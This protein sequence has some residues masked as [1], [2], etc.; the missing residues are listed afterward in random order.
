M[1]PDLADSFKEENEETTEEVDED[2]EVI[3]LWDTLKDIF[4]IYSIARMY[5]QEYYGL[6]STILLALIKEKSLLPSVV[7]PRIAYIHS[8]FVSI[9]SPISKD[10][11]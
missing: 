7:L 2:F 4:D 10:S 8:G 3:Y 5:L 11:E 9:V 1:F 6:D